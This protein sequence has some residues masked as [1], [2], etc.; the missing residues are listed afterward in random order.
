MFQSHFRSK[1]A[2]LHPGEA[3]VAIVEKVVLLFAAVI[4]LGSLQFL[5]EKTEDTF[6]VAQAGITAGE[7]NSGAHRVSAPLPPSGAGA[8]STAASLSF[9]NGGGTEF[10]GGILGAGCPDHNPHC[11][12]HGIGNDGDEPSNPPPGPGSVVTGSTNWLD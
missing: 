6:E 10:G 9:N 1:V 5:G 3:G 8:G 2:R 7:S 11:D 12:E 4:I